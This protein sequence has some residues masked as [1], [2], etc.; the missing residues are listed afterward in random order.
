MENKQRTLK[1]LAFMSLIVGNSA[2]GMDSSG[3]FKAIA[4]KWK[5]EMKAISAE[6][7]FY[8]DVIGAIERNQFGLRFS[9]FL[10]Q[11]KVV[12]PKL[13]S[14]RNYDQI[15]AFY[16]L[17]D[18][19]FQSISETIKENKQMIS[20]F[21]KYL[22]ELVSVPDFGA[23]QKS[24]SEAAGRSLLKTASGFGA[25]GAAAADGDDAQDAVT[26]READKLYDEMNL[27]ILSSELLC[28]KFDLNKFVP[29]L[30]LLFCKQPNQVERFKA[31][32]SSAMQKTK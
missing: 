26:C 13:N 10:T 15:Q 16:E 32:I 18:L 17:F 5:S 14:E 19:G 29:R 28:Q 25:A 12:L 20:V 6:D 27:D 8:Q 1:L 7:K 30:N 4:P 2:F 9:T 21:S 3:R 22:P 31:L 11:L 24:H 23:R